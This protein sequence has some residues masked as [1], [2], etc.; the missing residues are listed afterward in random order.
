[1]VITSNLQIIIIKNKVERDHCQGE[2]KGSIAD[3]IIANVKQEVYNG[4]NVEGFN[5]GEMKGRRER[6]KKWHW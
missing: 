1:M 6:R 4:K 3:E 5:S 2:D